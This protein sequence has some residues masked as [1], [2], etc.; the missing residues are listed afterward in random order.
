MDDYVVDYTVLDDS[1]TIYSRKFKSIEEAVDA[2]NSG[3]AFVELEK[4][5]MQ[6]NLIIRENENG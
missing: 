4:N 6:V 5:G 1:N 2:V 3:R